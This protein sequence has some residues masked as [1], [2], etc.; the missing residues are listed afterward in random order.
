MYNQERGVGSS[1][2][3]PLGDE[4]GVCSAMAMAMA[5]TGSACTAV[6]AGVPVAG[7]SLRGGRCGGGRRGQAAHQGKAGFLALKQCLSCSKTGAAAAGG[8]EQQQQQQQD[9]GFDGYGEVRDRCGAPRFGP[10]WP[11]LARRHPCSSSHSNSQGSGGPLSVRPAKS[12][13]PVCALR[14]CAVGRTECLGWLMTEVSCSE[15]A[16]RD[17]MRETGGER[18][19]AGDGRRE[20]VGTCPDSRG[21]ASDVVTTFPVAVRSCVSMNIRDVCV[22]NAGELFYVRRS[23]N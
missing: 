5:M 21:P 3:G 19:E 18:R 2:G 6:S 20:T 11:F 23:S 9:P 4:E 12:A 7:T 14:L 10:F 15:D 16:T 1:E 17:R 13:V 8:A 22:A